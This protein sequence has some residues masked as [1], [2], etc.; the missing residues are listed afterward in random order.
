MLM[1]YLLITAPWFQHWYVIWPLVIV[2][3]FPPGRSLWLAALFATIAIIKFF[4][5]TPLFLWDQLAPGTA[6]V[7]LWLG[8]AI[9]AIPCA[10]VIFAV[11][12]T[13]HV[14]A[15]EDA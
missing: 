3:L 6:A 9:M 5:I 15:H 13:R 7:E 14:E 4:V 1:F 2:A 12:R 8:P 10:F 11:W